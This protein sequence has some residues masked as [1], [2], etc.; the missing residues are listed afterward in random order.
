MLAGGKAADC[1]TS[2]TPDSCFDRT[3]DRTAPA[4]PRTPDRHRVAHM[5]AGSLPQILPEPTSDCRRMN[6]QGRKVAK[7]DIGEAHQPERWRRTTRNK[8]PQHFESTSIS[9]RHSRAIHGQSWL[10]LQSPLR[11][12]VA[13]VRGFVLER[14][15]NRRTLLCRR[16][17][18]N[19][20]HPA[21][22]LYSRFPSR[23]N[24]SHSPQNRRLMAAHEAPQG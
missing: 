13:H 4:K 3:S 1:A 2:C 19:S 24:S 22:N 10:D 7:E 8:Q 21:Q 17:T 6:F 5:M 11:P 12:Q 15:T 23:T 9:S 14:L 18:G 20:I 16:P